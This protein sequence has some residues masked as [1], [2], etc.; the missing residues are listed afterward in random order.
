MQ[1]RPNSFKYV[2]ESLLPGRCRVGDTAAL[3]GAPDSSATIR[4]KGRGGCSF[5]TA[6]PTVG[7]GG[8]DIDDADGAV[9]TTA[10]V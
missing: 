7:A 4:T 1:P 6:A 9:G 8:I 2:P 5:N 3:R 10:G